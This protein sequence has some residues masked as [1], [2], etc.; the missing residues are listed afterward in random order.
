MQTFYALSQSN[1]A[2]VVGLSEVL[3]SSPNTMFTFFP[4]DPH[5]IARSRIMLSIMA[6]R[7]VL[8]DGPWNDYDK[9]LDTLFPLKMAQPKAA[10]II[11]ES[12]PLLG[13]I[14]KVILNTKMA[15]FSGKSLS[16][17]ITLG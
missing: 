9:A 5:P 15:C 7:T 12:Q 8:G 16:A 17:N 14:C 2:S 13:L 3:I 10:K 1:F 6:C 4:N 11:M